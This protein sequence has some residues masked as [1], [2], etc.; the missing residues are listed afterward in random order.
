MTFALGRLVWPQMAVYSFGGG[1]R[2]KWGNVPGEMGKVSG[3]V[4]G[5]FG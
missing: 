1:F 3:A 5:S 2:A 4:K